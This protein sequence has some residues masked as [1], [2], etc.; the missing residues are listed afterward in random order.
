[1]RRVVNAKPA[2]VRLAVIFSKRLGKDRTIEP[3]KLHE[4]SIE[5]QLSE[6]EEHI[7]RLARWN[8]E[9]S[10]MPAEGVSSFVPGL[11]PRAGGLA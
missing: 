1:M 2:N 4:P 5:V 7:P 11:T 10:S 8:V 9:T 6:R 3:L